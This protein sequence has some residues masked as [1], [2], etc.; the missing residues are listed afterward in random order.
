V[1]LSAAE[2]QSFEHRLDGDTD[3]TAVAELL[4]Q[5]ERVIV[6]FGSATYT[7]KT[8]Q[9]LD[10]LAE[11]FGLALQIRF[12]GHHGSS[13]DFKTLLHLPH[14]ANLAV[15]CL[16]EA[17]NIEVL[18]ELECLQ[19]LKVGVF[20]GTPDEILSYPS[21]QHLERLTLGGGRSSGLVLDHLAGYQRLTDLHITGYT[22]GIE[23]LAEVK[24]LKRLSLSGI[25]NRQS[26]RFVSNLP[27]LREFSLLLGGREDI[28]EVVNPSIEEIEIIRVRGFSNLHAEN[29]VGLQHLQIQDQ[30]QLRSLIFSSA[31]RRLLSLCVAN[32]KSLQNLEGLNALGSLEQL[33]VVFTLVDF[34]GLVKMGLP[35]SLKTFAFHERSRRADGVI[36]K[37]L[38]ELGFVAQATS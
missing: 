26:L 15:D 33:R 27:S 6:Q 37:K 10:R 30:L 24:S 8:L 11:Q 22:K 9:R 12:F 3:P 7:K 16:D 34:E 1:R 28:K 32:C 14:V 38:T 36:Q 19:A 25:G 29:F 5:G 20:L 13:F 18:Q 31:S 4:A 35:S 23:Q 17:D 2:V 21:L